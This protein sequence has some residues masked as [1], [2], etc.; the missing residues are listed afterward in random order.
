MSSAQCIRIGQ[1]SSRNI[2]DELPRFLSLALYKLPKS[3]EI[4]HPP[5]QERLR[6]N[7]EIEA[8]IRLAYRP[9]QPARRAQSH[10][11]A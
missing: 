6:Q 3:Y 8:E 2:T 10:Q 1:S 11:A 5:F 9:S 7:P 4:R